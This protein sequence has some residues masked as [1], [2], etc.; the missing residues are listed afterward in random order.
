MNN[1][2]ED[3][4]TITNDGLDIDANNLD[5]NCITSKQNKFNMDSNGNLT[6]NTITINDSSF[7]PL[8]WDAIFNRIYPVGAIYISTVD[9]NPGLLFTGTWEKIQGKFLLG[10]NSTYTAGSTGGE[11]S[12]TLTNNEMPSHNHAPSTHG[13]NWV[14]NI[15]LG[16]QHVRQGTGSYLGWVPMTDNSSEWIWGTTGNRGGGQSHNN[17][18]PYLSVYMW[19]RVS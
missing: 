9:T 12:H 5:V 1:N 11:V 2:Y 13:N 19:K 10:E 7:N 16:R 8:S 17:M 3:Y 15:D 14:S 18:P 6:V 4:L